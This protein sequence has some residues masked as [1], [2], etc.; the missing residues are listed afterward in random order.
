MPDLLG[1]PLTLRIAVTGL[2]RAGKTVFLT[3]LLANLLALGRGRDT[4][5]AFTRALAG[6]APPRGIGV[7]LVPAATETIPR[8]EISEK[9]QTLAAATPAWPPRTE[10]VAAIA[11][12]LVVPAANPVLARFGP[13]RL[14]LEFLDYPGEWLLDLPLLDQDFAAWSA[15]TLRLLAEPARAGA[16]GRFLQAAATL[17]LRAPADEAALRRVHGLYKAAL[18][19]LRDELGFRTLQPG[20]FLTPGPR[21][22]APFLWFFPALA[23]GGAGSGAA[24]L[25]DRFAAYQQDIRAQAGLTR[26]ADCD[27]QIV[28]VDVLGALHAGRAAF[29]DTE[30]AIAAI[31]RFYRYGGQGVFRRLLGRA[32]RRL[33]LPAGA[34][35]I[36]RVAFVATKADHVPAS[37]RPALTGLLRAMAESGA[38]WAAPARLGISYHAVASIRAT[39]DVTV[40]HAGRSLEAVSGVP[41]GETVARPFYAGDLPG[42]QPTER[43]WQQPYFAGPAFQPPRIDPSGAT[44]IPHLGLDEL[45]L[46]LIG[47]RL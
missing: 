45:L 24:L 4:L 5:P 26:L 3:S 28:L 8:F 15:A 17:D 41:M 35:R 27:R 23:E 40:V 20:R 33:G 13:R 2:T 16:A 47:D 39:R 43:Y 22:D 1:G 19:Q 42:G 36:E 7:R 21:S 29:E 18:L 38:A 34:R 46:G 14:R 37:R 6:G 12:E 9:L 44:G 30:A 25:R 31:A 10:D 32:G 11:V